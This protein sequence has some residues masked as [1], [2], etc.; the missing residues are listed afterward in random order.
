MSVSLTK[1]GNVS[2]SKEAPGLTAV[3]VGLGWDV[4]TTT[5]ADFDLDAVALMVRR[6]GKILSDSHFIFFNNLTSPDGSVEHTGDNLTG[7]GEGDDEVIKVNLAAVPQEV[8]KIVVTVSI[9]DAEGRSQSFGQ[10]RNAF[11]RVVNQAGGARSP[12]TTCPRM[13]P[14]RPRWSSASCTATAPSGSSA[15]SARATAPACAASRRTTASTSAD[16][17]HPCSFAPYGCRDLRLRHRRGHRRLVAGLHLRRGH[18]ARA[19]RDPGRPRGLAVLRQR[20]R[21]RH[22]AGADEP[23]LAEALPHPRRRDRGLRHAAAVPAADRRHHR[24]AEPGRGRP[25]GAGQGRVHDEPGTYAYLL[26]QA[27]P[28][29]AAFGGMFLLMIFLDF[30]FEEREITWLS[31]LERP[32]G[33]DRQAG[34]ALRGH[35]AGRAGGIAYTLGPRRAPATTASPRCSSRASLGWRPICWSTAS[36][37][38][39]RQDEDEDERRRCRYRRRRSARE[40]AERNGRPC[41]SSGKAAF[42]LFLYLEV[43][44]A[45]FSFDGVIGAFAI[46]SDPII[47]A[48]GLGIGAMF[49]RSLTVF[50]VRKGTLSEYVFLEHGALWA[51]GALAVDPADHHRVRGAGARHRPDRGRIHRRRVRLFA[52]PQSASESRRGRCRANRRSRTSGG[53]AGLHKGLVPV[54]L[55]H[56][57]HYRRSIMG[58]DYTKRRRPAPD[59]G[60]GPVYR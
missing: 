47:I 17:A 25:A 19:V 23:V 13:P 49:I 52:D 8:D 35:R 2:L 50:L 9:Y 60:R 58:I 37:T 34:P 7:E 3:L 48:I 29:I 12:A 14:P 22:R 5:G 41:T 57:A 24:E 36:A 46:T 40:A 18:R 1:G 21:Q 43:L 42:F 44:D 59:I 27:H 53:R 38:S 11:I 33:P 6:T 54:R 32:A 31:W 4:R 39:S 10:V 16:P 30:I 15:R 28:A 45:S 55:D 20:G 26:K 51:I 56:P